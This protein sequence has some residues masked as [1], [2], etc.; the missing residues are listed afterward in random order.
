V[1]LWVHRFDTPSIDFV[2][3]LFTFIGSFPVIAFVAIAVLTWCWRR[4]DRDAF[5]ALFGVIAVNETLNFALKHLFG[6]PRPNLFQEIATLHSYSFPSGHAMA[7]AAI[8]GMIAVVIARLAP[9]LRLWA[10]LAA[11]ALALLIGLSR[12][13]LGVHWITDVLAGYAA[14]AT[15]LFGGILWLEFRRSD[16]GDARCGPSRPRAS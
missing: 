16:S 9:S 11:V 6:R 14:G 7:A 5:A 12:I 1:S 15:I 4:G 3:R 8:Y 13:Y 10:G 2:M